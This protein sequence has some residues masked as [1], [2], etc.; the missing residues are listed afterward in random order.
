MP[1]ISAGT[2][3][4]LRALVTRHGVVRA[5]LHRPVRLRSL[6]RRARLS[7]RAASPPHPCR[8][9]GVARPAET[10]DSTALS[11]RS[12][13]RMRPLFKSSQAHHTAS[14]QRE[15][16]PTIARA[17]QDRIIPIRD[18]GE[19]GSEAY[20]PPASLTCTFAG[21]LCLPW[22]CARPHSGQRTHTYTV[23]VTESA[24]WIDVGRWRRD[25]ISPLA[26]PRPLLVVRR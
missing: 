6:G 15:R 17:P 23:R 4:M 19:S 26:A 9:H 21:R 11:C 10:L 18:G 5:M 16:W 22:R 2:I 7:W 3:V 24:A 12:L 25:D 20:E 14:D 1:A 8:T 13:I